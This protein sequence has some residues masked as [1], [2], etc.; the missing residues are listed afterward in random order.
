MLE[1]L[2]DLPPGVEGVKATGKL[3]KEDYETVMV[4]LIDAARRDGRHLR[5][6]YQV[7]PEFHGFTSGAA[8]EDMKIGLHA[9]R[10]FDGCAVVS[11]VGWIRESTRLAAFLLPCP[12]KVFSLAEGTAAAEWLRSLPE[13]ATVAQRLIPE[14]GVLVIEITQALR[15]QDFDAIALTADS[16]IEAHGSLNGIV[17]HARAFPGWENV[18]ALL[19]HVRFVRDHHRKINRI[20]VAADSKVA[21]VAPR[22]GEHFIHAEVKVFGY[23]DLERAT[24]WA[25][26][27]SGE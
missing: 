7:G 3:S 14:T 25:G 17:I 19:H 12:V 6:L 23:D 10:L 16:W 2:R 9:L 8:W 24:A 27:S 4:P 15:S 21:S 26:G 22:I 13:G 11:D 20:A 5:L 18:G 1:I